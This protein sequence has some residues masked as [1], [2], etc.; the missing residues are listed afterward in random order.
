MKRTT[1]PRV[2]VLAAVVALAI[3][4][5]AAA[6]PGVTTGTQRLPAAGVTFANDPS[7][8]GLPTTTRYVVTNN[9]WA[10]GFTETAG[11]GTLGG[12]LNYNVLP[13]DYRKDMTADEERTYP[14]AQTPVQAHATCEGVPQ[15]D[16][17]TGGATILAWQ[18]G[19]AF[20]AT[21]GGAPKTEPAFNYVP[22]Q[23]TGVTVSGAPANLT[24]GGLLGDDP[25]TW[26]PVVKSATASVSGAPAGGVDLAKL[27][28]DQDFATA[29]SAIGGTYR[30]A[31]VATNIAS[32]LVSQAL[33]PFQA[34]VADL[35]KALTKAA[36]DKKAVDTKLASTEAARL[37]LVNRTLT[38]AL[39]KTSF[40]ADRG[41]AMVT[42]PV[43]Q[44][45][46]VRLRRTGKVRTVY[47]R[48]KVV[49]QSEGAV[50]V[51]L[52]P[53]KKALAEIR[54]RQ[55]K[56]GKPL[57]VDVEV[58]SPLGRTTTPGTVLR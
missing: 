23:K 16:P 8:S 46:V 58:I 51:N 31:D 43:G 3:P 22:W 41:V 17:A 52:E 54:A 50:L 14:D 10:V 6:E 47:T 53:S 18:K 1:P 11:S 39:A 36:A 37:A 28:T 27:T 56:T 25:S 34:Q 5:A 12:V 26:I 19:P 44:E 2:T 42:G 13:A 9:G 35:N 38:V 20:T 29:C 32:T 57:E 15:L 45:V 48:D 4:A 40:K 24:A 7:G 55:A 30:K 49:I 21:V 33:A